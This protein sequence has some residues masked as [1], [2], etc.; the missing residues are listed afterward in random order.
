[1]IVPIKRP[2]GRWMDCV[3]RDTQ[4]RRIT[5]EDAQDKTFWK[6]RIM[7]ADPN[8][9]IRT[10]IKASLENLIATSQICE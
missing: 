3:R 4:E 5:P 2:K 10:L 9:K 6:S 8:R 1:M 7:A